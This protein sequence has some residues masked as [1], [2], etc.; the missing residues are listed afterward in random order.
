MLSMQGVQSF[1]N[2]ATEKYINTTSVR[3]EFVE[4]MRQDKNFPDNVS[5]YAEI[6]SYLLKRGA[7]E[8]FLRI[9]KNIYKSY[10]RVV[11]EGKKA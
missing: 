11:L 1:Y 7:D 3:G 8:E 10:S 2:W 9:A 4:D 6:K 5:D